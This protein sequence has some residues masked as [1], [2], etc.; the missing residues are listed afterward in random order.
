MSA[1]LDKVRTPTR[2][3]TD[4][5]PTTGSLL[6][7]AADTH[8]G[9]SVLYVVTLV[10]ATVAPALGATGTLVRFGCAFLVV[11]ALVHSG[12]GE[13]KPP[14]LRAAQTVACAVFAGVLVLSVFGPVGFAYGVSRL[15][16]W[17]MFAPL[18]V[19]FYRRPDIRALGVAGLVI[20]AVQSVGV[21]LQ[22][23]GLFGG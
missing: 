16:N 17:L 8:W 22:M 3:R 10:A 20:G 12:L 5:E 21:L 15:L 19:L 11:V 14:R 18:A 13:T 1:V 6:A 9:Y 23:R 7:A 4:G 2:H